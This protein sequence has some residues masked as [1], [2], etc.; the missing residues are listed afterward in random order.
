MLFD[1]HTHLNLAAFDTDRDFLLK[2]YLKQ[3]IFLVNVGT[4]YQTSK[5]AI[6]LANKYSNCWA[7][8]GLHPAH[9]FPVPKQQLDV[10]EL[11]VQD[12]S[13]KRYLEAEDFDNNFELLLDN[14]RVVAVGECGLDYTYCEKLT[15]EQQNQAKLLQAKVF[16]K[17]IK[18]AVKHQ[19]PLI[20]H[21]RNLYQEAISILGNYLDPENKAVFHFFSGTMDDLDTILSHKQ[22]FIGFSGVITYSNRLDEVIKRTPLERI[23]I[24]TDAPYVAPR[25]YRGKRNEPAFVLEVARKIADI[26]KL[27]L[28]E[29]E[30]VTFQNALDF[31]NISKFQ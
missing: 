22:Y 2:K 3:G 19:L 16:E 13:L 25:P 1:S 7:S 20:L 15:L 14:D 24:E 17:Q 8:V 5:R 4:C 12:T 27:S 21:L 9:A 30:K 18:I 26:K 11:N 10:E 23:L 6:E 29:I 28:D 31:F